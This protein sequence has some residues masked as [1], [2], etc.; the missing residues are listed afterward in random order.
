MMTREQAIAEVKTIKQMIN[1]WFKAG[2]NAPE[3]AYN[4][5]SELMKEFEIKLEELR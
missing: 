4:R 5:A 3:S 1:D 2:M